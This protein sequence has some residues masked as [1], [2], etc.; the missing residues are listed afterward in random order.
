MGPLWVVVRQLPLKMNRD[1][2]MH[3]PRKLPR[4]RAVWRTRP[5]ERATSGIFW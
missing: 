5:A 2:H 4:R 3:L 1:P